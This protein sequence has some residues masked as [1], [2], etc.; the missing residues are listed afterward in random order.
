LGFLRGGQYAVCLALLVDGNVE[1]GVLGCPNFSVSAGSSERGILLYGVKGDKA[2][3][4]SLTNPSMQT[5]RV[6]QMTTIDDISEA[7]ICE[8]VESRHASHDQQSRIANLLGIKTASVR[9]DS[10]A[11][12]AALARGDAEIYLRLPVDMDYQEKIWVIS[13]EV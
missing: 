12:Y 4:T 3:E 13:P 8:N 1:V 2:Y 7:R 5:A 11:K 10:Q 9:M 6:C